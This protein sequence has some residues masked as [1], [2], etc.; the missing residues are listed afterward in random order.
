M[1]WNFIMVATLPKMKC[2]H[3]KLILK[4]TEIFLPDEVCLDDSTPCI[5]LTI[6]IVTKYIIDSVFA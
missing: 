2:K 4:L 3:K 1:I 5:S 6:Y